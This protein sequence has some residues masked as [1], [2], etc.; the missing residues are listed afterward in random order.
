MRTKGT[1]GEEEEEEEEEGRRSKE[2][3]SCEV[4]QGEEGR[5]GGDIRGQK[6]QIPQLSAAGLFHGA[7]KSRAMIGAGIPFAFKRPG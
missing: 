7:P 3:N 1:T 5:G 4:E 2:R 6:G